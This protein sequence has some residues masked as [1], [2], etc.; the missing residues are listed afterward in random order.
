L[1]KGPRRIITQPP[2]GL[3]L[4]APYWKG[5]RADAIVAAR[6]A[7]RH[8]AR[9]AKK[10]ARSGQRAATPNDKLLKRLTRALARR[11]TPDGIARVTARIKALKREMKRA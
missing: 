8:A 6:I 9:A 7:A 4:T 5:E 11:K 1:Q 2:R 10:P 3:D